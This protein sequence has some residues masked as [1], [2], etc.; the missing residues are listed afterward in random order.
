MTKDEIIQMADCG[1]DYEIPRKITNLKQG[2]R[3]E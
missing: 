3:N 2:L 1:I